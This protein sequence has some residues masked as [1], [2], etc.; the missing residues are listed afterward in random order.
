MSNNALATSRPEDQ[1]RAKAELLYR[2]IQQITE[3]GME[4][5]LATGLNAIMARVTRAFNLSQRDPLYTA[6]AQA[7][8]V[9]TINLG[10]EYATSGDL[11]KAVNAL[12]RNP[13]EAIYAIGEKVTTE[14]RKRVTQVQEEAFV[15]I[16]RNNSDP[17]YF[18]VTD[19]STENQLTAWAT[20]GLSDHPFLPVGSMVEINAINAVLNHVVRE[21]VLAKK[22]GWNQVLGT[23]SEAARFSSKIFARL[24]KDTCNTQGG[25]WK[26]FLLSLI[27]Q[28]MGQGWQRNEHHLAFVDRFAVLEFLDLVNNHFDEINDRA[29]L[30]IERIT[31]VATRRYGDIVRIG[32]TPAE[33]E[34]IFGFAQGYLM[35]LSEQAR[36]FYATKSDEE[37]LDAE[38]IDRFWRE[39]LFLSSTVPYDVRIAESGAAWEKVSQMKTLSALTRLVHGFKSWP[40]DQQAKFF[41]EVDLNQMIDAIDRAD[42][43]AKALYELFAVL[44]TDETSVTNT[45]SVVLHC[46]NWSRRVGLLMALQR[47]EAFK[48]FGPAIVCGAELATWNFEQILALRQNDASRAYLGVALRNVDIPLSNEQWSKVYELASKDCGISIAQ[49]WGAIGPEQQNRDFMKFTALEFSSLIS[50]WS[51][52]KVRTFFEPILVLHRR[53]QT[54]QEQFRF[55]YTGQ[56]GRNLGFILARSW[57]KQ[58][59]A[60]FHQYLGWKTREDVFFESLPAGHPDR[61]QF[62]RQLN[63]VTIEQI[64]KDQPWLRLSGIKSWDELCEVL[65]NFVLWP[66]KEQDGL[67]FS[68]FRVDHLLDQLPSPKEQAAGVIRLSKAMD[69]PYKNSEYVATLLARMI[70]WQSRSELALILLTNKT[71]PRE[72]V[73]KITA[74]AIWPVVFSRELLED[75]ELLK[76]ALS[77]M[78]TPATDQEWE[79]LCR[80]GA[81]EGLWAVEKAWSKMTGSEKKRFF[82]RFTAQQLSGLFVSITE[83]EVYN[84]FKEILDEHDQDETF[85]VGFK[86]WYQGG[87]Q[88]RTKFFTLNEWEERLSKLFQ[89]RL[90]WATKNETPSKVTKKPVAEV[91]DQTDLLVIGDGL[92]QQLDQITDAKA[93]A[94]ALVDLWRAAGGKSNHSAMRRICELIDWTN[95]AAVIA[96]L[97]LTEFEVEQKLLCELGKKAK[98]PYEVTKSIRKSNRRKT[99]YFEMTLI[100]VAHADPPL[101]PEDWAHVVCKVGLYNPEFG[102]GLWALMPNEQRQN[103]FMKLTGLLV[104]DIFRNEPWEVVGEFFTAVLSVPGRHNNFKTMFENWYFGDKTQSGKVYAFK[105]APAWST[106]IDDLICKLLYGEQAKPKG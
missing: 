24:R 23:D 15:S 4:L 65:K 77:N 31:Q 82:M 81:S 7:I 63:A 3:T 78:R 38:V 2:A 67:A 50:D 84:F 14:L 85:Q 35:E 89:E 93:Q 59:E 86:S 18:G 57:E 27:M 12:T 80:V 49:V 94:E 56:A 51:W 13:I 58:L 87:R 71:Q 10:L 68:V 62:D 8:A 17:I 33:I 54:F 98:W 52:G 74:E 5:N 46:I 91:S 48:R 44:E 105:P 22:I 30:A 47:N 9:V 83:A 101:T 90:G 100:A 64:E 41:N 25:V 26:P 53:D 103:L 28:A 32:Y 29:G 6:K 20:K 42:A 106:E 97:N 34:E 66:D 95:R 73:K 61:K 70:D 104:S 19:Q 76:V 1:A 37:I 69:G 21:T 11:N 60:L 43:Q 72:R 99:H 92:E 96:Q 40:A 36:T 75:T 55:W 102:K 39:R 16:R 45:K 79:T 88:G